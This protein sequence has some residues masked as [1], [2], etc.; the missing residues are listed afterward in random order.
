MKNSRRADLLHVEKTPKT[1]RGR[2]G[3]FIFCGLLLYLHL[4]VCLA[5][6]GVFSSPFWLFEKLKKHPFSP[7]SPP[8][9]V[10]EDERRM[11]AP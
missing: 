6:D 10:G 1:H 2:F 3:A 8:A 4:P 11:T 5:A 7:M 9:G